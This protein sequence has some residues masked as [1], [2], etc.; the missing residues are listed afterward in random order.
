MTLLI[1]SFLLV[2]THIALSLYMFDKKLN[3]IIHKTHLLRRYHILMTVYLVIMMV[4]WSN[5]LRPFTGR[6][7][8]KRHLNKNLC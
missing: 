5:F 8:H 2:Y 3:L 6:F 7:I 1:H 4:N